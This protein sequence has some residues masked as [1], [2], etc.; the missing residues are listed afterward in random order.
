MP[1]QIV[2]GWWR[3]DIGGFQ[4]GR[5][6]VQNDLKGH[7]LFD[8]A[9]GLTPDRIIISEQHSAGAKS[10]SFMV[11]KDQ[12]KLVY[13]IQYPNQLFDMEKDP[14]ER[15]D[16]SSDPAFA[17]VAENMEAELRKILDPEDIDRKAKADQ[18]ARIEEGGGQDAIVSKG[19]PGYTPAPGEKPVYV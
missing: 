12:Y 17:S 3:F 14:E 7:S 11:R 9:N 8:L 13:H 19:S 4:N 1:F 2:F 18:A 5:E 10:A 15:N 6:N 16:L